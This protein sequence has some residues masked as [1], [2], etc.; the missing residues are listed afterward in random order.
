MH[1]HEGTC[2]Y[3]SGNT[4]ITLCKELTPTFRVSITEISRK[5]FTSMHEDFKIYDT[6]NKKR[7]FSFFLF[8]GRNTE[9]GKFNVRKKACM[10]EKRG[11]TIF[12]AKKKLVCEKKKTCMREKKACMREKKACMRK[13]SLYERKKLVC[14]KKK[15]VCEKK[16]CMREKKNLYARKKKACMREK[17]TCMREKNLYA[18]KKS[19]YARKKHLVCEKKSLY[20]YYN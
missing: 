19:L 18:R 13:K 1:V 11:K 8:Q 5:L 2:T 9:N 17:K 6:V 14:E 3:A 12:Y 20:T 15:L 16:A 7:D 4:R 10:R